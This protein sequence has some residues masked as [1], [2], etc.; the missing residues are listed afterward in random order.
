[1]RECFKELEHLEVLQAHSDVRSCLVLASGL[2]GT[3]CIRI[4]DCKLAGKLEILLLHCSKELGRRSKM[5]YV[6]EK[7]TVLVL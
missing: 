3:D 1:V 7:A 4:L 2:G 6:L 5:I